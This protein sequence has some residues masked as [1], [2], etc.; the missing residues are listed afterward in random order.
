MPRLSWN[1]SLLVIDDSFTL[2][3][4]DAGADERAI[5]RAY[6]RRLRETRPDED[7]I[8]FQA[9]NEAYRQCLDHVAWRTKSGEDSGDEG[10]GDDQDA[11]S[12]D[13]GGTASADTLT[14]RITPEALAA[15][16]RLDR[17]LLTEASALDSMA[18]DTDD[19]DEFEGGDRYYALDHDKFIAGLLEASS[20]GSAA[21]VH[22][23]L[24]AHPAFYAVGAREALAPQVLSALIEAPELP[25]RHLA[26]LLHFFG[27]DEVGHERD[28]LWPRIA[29]LQARARMTPEHTAAAN[30]LFGQ[31]KSIEEEGS[32]G[33]D[34]WKIWLI[35]MVFI[36]LMRMVASMVR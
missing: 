31:P 21:D 2:L 1:L 8:A 15:A 22:R 17:Q 33:W 12:V 25:P 19:D 4:L 14:M 9:L 35:M 10:W 6:A 13:A 34:G 27:L 36:A 32:G 3:Q 11:S 29:E 30:E 7:P 18:P 26:A 23:W 20:V 5:K 16:L 28:W 24:Q